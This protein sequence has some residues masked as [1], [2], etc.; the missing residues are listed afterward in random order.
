[1]NGGSVSNFQIQNV[2]ILNSNVVLVP[3]F[4]VCGSML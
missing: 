1:M 4:H 2:H 3:Q